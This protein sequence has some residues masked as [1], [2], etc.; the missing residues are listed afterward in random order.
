MYPRSS[1]L[2]IVAFLLGRALALF[3]EA[4]GALILGGIGATLT[5]RYKGHESQER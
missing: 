5:E 3:R 2:C 1:F 4:I